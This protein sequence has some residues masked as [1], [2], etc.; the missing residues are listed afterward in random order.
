MFCLYSCSGCLFFL[1]FLKQTHAA[2]LFCPPCRRSPSLITGG[3]QLSLLTVMVVDLLVRPCLLF[4]K[5]SF[6]IYYYLHWCIICTLFSTM[7]PHFTFA[8]NVA[9]RSISRGSLSFP[10]SAAVLSVCSLVHFYSFILSSVFFICP[11]NTLP[12]NQLNK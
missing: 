4:N 11:F 7:L 2:S 5:S 6:T 3:R 8:Q 12:Q 10:C 9:A 1:P